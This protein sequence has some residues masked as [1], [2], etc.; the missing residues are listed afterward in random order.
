[1]ATFGPSTHD[2]LAS[3]TRP[4][5]FIGSRLLLQQRCYGTL[6]H[7]LGNITSPVALLADVVEAGRATQLPSAA[8]TLRLIATSLSRATTI[9]RMLRG[10]TDA[11]ALSPLT[12]PD[13]SAWWT[14]CA[15]F[16]SDM[17]PASASVRADI[18]PVSLTMAQY[19]ALVWATI[20]IAR[21]TADTRPS[22]T[23]LV[24]AG[25]ADAK[26]SAF[27]LHIS[28]DTPRRGIVH[29]KTRQLLMLAS[30]EVRRV[31]GRMLVADT[32]A[33]FESRI[34]LPRT[35]VAGQSDVS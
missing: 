29:S 14:L 5:N 11:G 4:A 31:G 20:A 19:E 34:T 6:A 17:L 32:D 26:R 28:T 23:S 27:A 8:S 12:M 25:A 1:M 30:W 10:D 16:T 3:T 22:I 18:A 35:P 21:F 9:C 2:A 33:G 13:A 24:V 15:P 7:E